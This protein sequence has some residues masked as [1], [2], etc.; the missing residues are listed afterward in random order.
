MELGVY[1]FGDV[2]RD[3]ISGALGSTA[4]AMR[5]LREAIALADAVGLDYFGVGEHHTYEM[6]ASAGAV[7]LASAASITKRIKLGSAVTVLST[8]DPV[9]ILS[10]IRH[11][12]RAV[13]RSCR[14]HRWSWLFDRIV[15]AVRIQ[16]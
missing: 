11:S 13:Q 12:G 7:I 14:D 1:S 15:P 2:Q 3:L 6:P 8:D 5:N 9:R 16:P 4:E 10:A